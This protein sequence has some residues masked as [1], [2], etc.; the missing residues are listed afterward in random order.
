MRCRLLKGF[1]TADWYKDYKN[2]V[3]VEIWGR[4]NEETDE[5]VDFQLRIHQNAV[6]SCSGYKTLDEVEKVYADR[7]EY[8]SKEYSHVEQ[9]EKDTEAYEKL[10]EELFTRYT[11]LSKEMYTEPVQG[12]SVTGNLVEVIGEQVVQFLD[13]QVV[14]QYLYNIVGFTPKNGKPFASHKANIFLL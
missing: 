13:G 8:F 3:S 14:E 6:D 12:G 5:I 4:Y 11:V 10:V 7:K 1:Y 9:K 2:H